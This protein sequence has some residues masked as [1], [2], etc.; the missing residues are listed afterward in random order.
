MELVLS[1]TSGKVSSIGWNGRDITKSVRFKDHALM[2][3]HVSGGWLTETG[4]S[5]QILIRTA[6]ASSSSSSVAERDRYD[7]LLDGERFATLPRARD[8]EQQRR[9]SQQQQ[10]QR[11]R[12][13]PTDERGSKSSSSQQCRVQTET[14]ARRGSA[15]TT[16]L[17][18]SFDLLSSNERVESDLKY[19]LSLA[20]LERHTEV[21]I[22]PEDEIQ[23]EL[24]S[25][26]F[27]PVVKTL[28]EVII[29]AM[30][31]SEH[32][33]SRAIMAGFCSDASSRHSMDS[34]SIDGYAPPLE[35]EAN[36]LRNAWYWTR[37]EHHR[38]EQ[39]QFF[40]TQLEEVMQYV[41]AETFD[42]EDAARVTLNIAAIVGLDMACPIPY[43]T[44]L[45]DGIPVGMNEQELHVAFRE[46]GI[47]C[48]AAAS[49]TLTF[50]FCRF[51][52]ETSAATCVAD[53]GF[54]L[55]GTRPSLRLL[56]ATK[57]DR[58][59]QLEGRSVDKSSP[60]RTPSRDAPPLDSQTSPS[61]VTKYLFD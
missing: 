35:V 11:E 55:E 23:D 10:Q 37:E 2:A 51:E 20:G 24:H 5:I 45:V 16:S 7:L 1:K 59:K 22:D 47:V 28:R 17:A 13:S 21:A 25:E 36:L 33:V 26:R 15:T 46:Y 41:R 57:T 61:C 31:Q 12:R 4:Q 53:K 50:G 34:M 9:G 58:N 40:E 54:T 27:S 18:D 52:S 8:M 60:L 44:V 32:T 56:R 39:L 29:K 42:A 30:P 3:Q 49:S 19:R 14:T 38:S 6:A 43:T 48:A